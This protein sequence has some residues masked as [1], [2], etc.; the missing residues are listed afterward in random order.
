MACGLVVFVFFLKLNIRLVIL[1]LLVSTA[2]A[3]TRWRVAIGLYTASF[4]YATIDSL[5]I[6]NM[7]LINPWA[8]AVPLSSASPRASPRGFSPKGL[9]ASQPFVPQ[10]PHLG[11]ALR[12]LPPQVLGFFLV[13]GFG[14][15]F[16]FL[17]CGAQHPLSVLSPGDWGRFP[18]I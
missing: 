13:V 6:K 10:I 16:F 15:V 14:W 4:V 2:V 5:T 11:A 18:S 17:C 1:L 3:S 9:W 12:P 7:R 8:A